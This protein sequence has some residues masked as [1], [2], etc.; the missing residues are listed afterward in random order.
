MPGPVPGSERASFEAE[1]VIQQVAGAG[2][3]A[4][5][6]ALRERN[7]GEHFEVLVMVKVPFDALVPNAGAAFSSSKTDDPDEAMVL[8]VQMLRA[9]AEA[10]ER[11]VRARGLEP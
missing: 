7:L 8:S 2:L 5:K 11:A 6:S 10:A 1:T 9:Q 3:D 4:V